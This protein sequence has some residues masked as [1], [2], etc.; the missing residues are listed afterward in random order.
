MHRNVFYTIARWSFSLVRYIL[1]Q[2][3][4]WLILVRRVSGLALRQCVELGYH[5]NFKRFG[6]PT[7]PLREE[8]RKRVFW[9]AYGIDVAAATS[10]GRPPGIS[11][12]EVDAEVYQRTHNL[13]VQVPEI[14]KLTTAKPSIHWTSTILSL[15]MMPFIEHPEA[16]LKMR[17][18]AYLTQFIPSVFDEFGLAYIRHYIQIL[19][20]VIL[21]T[22]PTILELRVYVPSS[23][24]GGRQLLLLLIMQTEHFPFSWAQSGSS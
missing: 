11:L 1:N 10:L 22:K 23:K 3:T 17:P 5:R 9:C 6:A 7:S 20:S 12:Q 4:F 21:R 2:T 14:A 18:R 8:L 16:L 15:R 24:N 19:P 13:Q